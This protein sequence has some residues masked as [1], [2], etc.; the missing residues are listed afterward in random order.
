GVDLEQLRC[1]EA[2]RLARVERPRGQRAVAPAD[3]V[4]TRDPEA[5]EPGQGEL[6]EDRAGRL[7][8]E[9]PVERPRR[10]LIDG[11]RERAREELERERD[12]PVG[13]RG[14]GLL[15]EADELRGKAVGDALAVE[16]NERAVVDEQ[17]AALRAQLGDAGDDAAAEAVT[18]EDRGLVE[19]V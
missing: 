18:D 10:R 17:R 7:G 11:V 12:R 6:L 3:D 16:G 4:R 13:A 2:A 15:E 19:I 1:L 8:D 14:R 5:S 9:L